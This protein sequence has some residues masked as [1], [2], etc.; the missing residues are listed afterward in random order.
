[1]RRKEKRKANSLKN[2]T[3]S[4][5]ALQVSALKRESNRRDMHAVFPGSQGKEEL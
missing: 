2:K 4:L 3:P 1:M 5:R